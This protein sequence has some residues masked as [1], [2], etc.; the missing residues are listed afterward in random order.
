M[1]TGR[2][3]FAGTS[4]AS[5]IASILTTRPPVGVVKRVWDLTRMPYL[6]LWTTSSSGAW[7]SIRISDGRQ[8]AI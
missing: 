7:Q 3:A 6:S 2:K 5:L 4:Q 1:A 8:R